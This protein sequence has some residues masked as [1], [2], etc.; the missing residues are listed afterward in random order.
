MEQRQFE[1]IKKE[2]EKYPLKIRYIY[3][4]Q[5][6][7][8]IEKTTKESSILKEIDKLLKDIEAKFSHDTSWKRDILTNLM[9]S[10]KDEERLNERHAPRQETID[11]LIANTQ[12]KPQEQ[13]AIR[14]G[15]AS[16][17]DGYSKQG[18]LS[19]DK[20]SN[21][22]YS[23][24]SSRLEEHDRSVSTQEQQEKFAAGS[25]HRKSISE[26]TEEHHKGRKPIQQYK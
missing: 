1:L 23:T 12:P 18:Y 2:L 9:A 8:Y 17:E 15:S 21:D 24:S 16:E 13:A 3:L 20:K 19:K 5:L 11:Q 10:N 4:L 7:K 6:Q 26:E 14:Y 25:Y 22:L